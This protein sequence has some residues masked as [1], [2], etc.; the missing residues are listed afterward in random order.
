MAK[1]KEQTRGWESF[2]QET[3][4]EYITWKYFKDNLLFEASGSNKYVAYLFNGTYSKRIR[5]NHDELQKGLWLKIQELIIIIIID[6]NVGPSLT[7]SIGN[8]TGGELYINNRG[9]VNTKNQ[10]VL[11]N[12]QQPPTWR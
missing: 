9:C 8:Y 3:V 4:A 7:L 6:A 1:I 2:C 11:F 12:G 10:L 5:E